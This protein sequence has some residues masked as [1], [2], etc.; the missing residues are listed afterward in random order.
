MRK[1]NKVLLEAEHQLVFGHSLGDVSAAT[2]NL[3]QV[4][5]ECLLVQL[6]ESKITRL[7]AKPLRDVSPWGCNDLG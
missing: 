6:L 7:R 4:L 3:R 5:P 1:H 2:N